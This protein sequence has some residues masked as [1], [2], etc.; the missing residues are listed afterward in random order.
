MESVSKEASEIQA[1]QLCEGNPPK[2]IELPIHMVFPRLFVCS[3]VKNRNFKIEF[4]LQ[5][6]IIFESKHEA[7]KIIPITLSRG[8]EQV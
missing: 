3:T 7:T 2:G 6:V 4:E 8:M 1:L 5:F